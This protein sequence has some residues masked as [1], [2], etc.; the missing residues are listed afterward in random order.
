MPCVRV[1]VRVCVFSDQDM[2][3]GAKFNAAVLA[4]DVQRHRVDVPLRAEPAH[5]P[6][7]NTTKLHGPACVRV[8]M[9]GKRDRAHAKLLPLE[10]LNSPTNKYFIG[11]S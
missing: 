4:H 11:M 2:R 9:F 10:T 6:T 1:C 7:S 3:S 8:C 5:Q